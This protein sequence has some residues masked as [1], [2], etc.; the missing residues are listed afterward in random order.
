MYYNDVNSLFHVENIFE[1][2]TKKMIE[3]SHAERELKEVEVEIKALRARKYE[4]LDKEELTRGEEEELKDIPGR[5]EKLEA[6]KKFW[7]EIIE[8]RILY[9]ADYRRSKCYDRKCGNGYRNSSGQR[10]PIPS[11][12]IPELYQFYRSRQY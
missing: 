4:L 5:L 8:K 11:S 2:L 10:A 6:D 3:M 9:I 12:N 1:A 7:Q